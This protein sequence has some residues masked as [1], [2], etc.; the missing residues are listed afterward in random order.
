MGRDSRKA[1]GRICR[2]CKH[3]MAIT[4]EELKE[5]TKTC[6]ATIKAAQKEIKY[7]KEELTFNSPEML[8]LM[9]K[10]ATKRNRWK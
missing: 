6:W 1:K 3:T 7:T 4:A 8:G 2:G 10:I 9:A 5:H